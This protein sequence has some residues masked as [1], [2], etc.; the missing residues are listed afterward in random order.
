MLGT[1]QIAMLINTSQESN[2]SSSS[3]L[4]RH[5][6]GHAGVLDSGLKDMPRVFLEN[7]LQYLRKNCLNISWL[8]PFKGL[9]VNCVAAD[10][11]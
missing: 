1:Y 4:K 7:T 5:G 11:H 10:Q 2:P 9:P 6:A 3:L 8:L